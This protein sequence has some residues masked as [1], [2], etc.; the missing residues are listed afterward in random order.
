MSET[1]HARDAAWLLDALADEANSWAVGGFGAIAEFTR[2]PGEPAT[3]ERN[4][5]TASIATGRGAIR[6][7]LRD[8]LEPVAYETPNRDGA[9]WAQA[10]ALC[11][12]AAASATSRRTVLTE[13][14]PDTEAIRPQDRDAL[15]FDM[16]LGIAQ[17]DICIRTREPELVAILRSGLG[18][19][20]FEPG[21]PAM[22]AIVRFG[23]HRV[24][25]CG[26]GRCEVFQ[27]IPPPDGKSPDGPHT[28]VLPK[29]LRT[30]R[31]HA[32]TTPIPDGLVPALISSRRARSRTRWAGASP[33]MSGATR[34]S[35]A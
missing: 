23:P 3:T 5:W 1:S 21:H 32:A 29:L 6:L 13:L 25:T 18:R 28:H 26:F 20:L 24:F 19:S 7:A 4:G 31:T 30:G 2:D 34:L 17:S 10:V 16:E 9:T 14:G 15:V 35:P 22:P 12:P 27:P 11:L 33:S 8:D